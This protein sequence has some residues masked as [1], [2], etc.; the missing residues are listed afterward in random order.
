MCQQ[1]ATSLK[2]P[3]RSR[4]AIHIGNSD[5]SDAEVGTFGLELLSSARTRL[6]PPEYCLEISSLPARVRDPSPLCVAYVPN[7]AMKTRTASC[8]R[9][10]FSRE[11]GI[12]SFSNP[13]MCP[14]PMNIDR[15]KSAACRG[16]RTFSVP[17][18]WA[19]RR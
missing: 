2:L 11:S 6:L 3:A 5:R 12:L 17:A 18:A 1:N 4:L 16:L 13:R 9:A 7:A 15:N 14:E 8:R 19:R 10:L